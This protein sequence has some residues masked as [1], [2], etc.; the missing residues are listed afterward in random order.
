MLGRDAEKAGVDQNV[1]IGP[2]Q[3]LPLFNVAMSRG[4]SKIPRHPIE[5]FNEREQGMSSVAI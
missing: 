5:L 1:A 3:F 4:W 2:G